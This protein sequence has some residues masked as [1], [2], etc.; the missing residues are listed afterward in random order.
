[1]TQTAKGPIS[2]SLNAGQEGNALH[3]GEEDEL[4]EDLVQ[5]DGHDHMNG[6]VTTSTFCLPPLLFSVFG[7]PLL[8]RGFSGPGGHLRIR[9]WNPLRVV[10]ADG[11]EWV[12][13]VLVRQLM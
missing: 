3:N 9:I 12:W 10:A 6:T 8:P 1:M 13:S 4:R 5:E 11:R 2:S 7:R